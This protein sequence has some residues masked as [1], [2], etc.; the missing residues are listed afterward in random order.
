MCYVRLQKGLRENYESS[1][2]QFSNKFWTI[3]NYIKSFSWFISDL[4]YFGLFRLSGAISGYL[5][6]SPARSRYLRLFP[7]ISGYLR[8]SLAISGYLGLIPAISGYLQLSPAISSYLQLTPATSGYLLLFWAISDFS[9]LSPFIYGYYKQSWAI[10]IKGQAANRSR[11][12]QVI[13]MWNLFG[14]FLFSGMNHRG[15]CS[16]KNVLETF[17]KLSPSP[18]AG[19]T[20]RSPQSAICLPSTPTT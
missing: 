11:I 8:L 15:D 9:W 4:D 5:Q 2:V 17:A 19:L 6:L 12:E 7:A 14:I 3:L 13:A 20:V 10:S 1:R 16:F 18:N